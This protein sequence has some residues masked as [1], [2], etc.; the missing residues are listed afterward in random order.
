MLAVAELLN[1]QPAEV[2][3]IENATRAWDMAFYSI[4]F[5][6]GDRIL[7]C[8]SE[9]VSNYIS[10]LQVARKTGAVVEVV[11]SDA[12]GQVDLE[13]LERMLKQG[14]VRLVALTHVP[15]QGG[16]INPAVEAGRL[17]T[18]HG[19]LFLLDACQS[20][21]QLALDVQQLGCD[22]L[23]GTG[24]K[25]LRGPRG[26]GFLYA[27]QAAMDKIEPVFLDLHS[28]DW[29]DGGSYRVRS[30]ARKF[31]NWE[32]FYAGK[33]ALGTAV[34]YALR[35]G[36]SAIE[37]RVLSLAAH[38]REMASTIPGVNVR[39]IGVRKSGIVT[40][41]KEGEEATLL[42]IRLQASGI[43][44]SVSNAS[45]ARLDFGRRNLTSVL[46]ASVHYYNTE[47]EIDRFVAELRR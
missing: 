3:F 12:S 7:T 23:S 24:R 9:Y 33:A 4:G 16:L 17:T 13:A 14:R 2:A 1:C 19:A 21:G 27:R 30:D 45:S 44:T 8:E 31:E 34:R 11:P 5:K 42:Q 38:M 43:N 32:C 36:M 15:T 47:D 10:L 46:R 39:D 20:V 28:A 26:T 40:L 18:A 6:P 22:F 35:L 29:I 37:S 25:F 41:T